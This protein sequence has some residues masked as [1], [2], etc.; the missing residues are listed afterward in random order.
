MKL[1]KKIQFSKCHSKNST[2][3]KASDTGGDFIRPSLEIGRQQ[4]LTIFAGAVFAE[5]PANLMAI[6][7]KSFISD[8]DRSSRRSKSL[9]EIAVTAV[10]MPEN[11]RWR[12]NSPRRA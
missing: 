2:H 9:A 1:V 11:F 10:G 6:S 8:F 7:G 4:S 5:S 12:S 3:S